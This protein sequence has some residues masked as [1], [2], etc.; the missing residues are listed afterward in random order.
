MLWFYYNALQTVCYKLIIHYKGF[1]PILPFRITLLSLTT[2]NS[3]SLVESYLGKYTEDPVI[4]AFQNKAE[5]KKYVI[6]KTCYYRS[7]ELNTS[8]YEAMTY[9]GDK[10]MA[11]WWSPIKWVDCQVHHLF[12]QVHI[13]KMVYNTRVR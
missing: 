13:Y 7:S 12:W 10:L 8:T 5:F 9:V 4:V 2:L 11:P 6:E 3:L 1:L